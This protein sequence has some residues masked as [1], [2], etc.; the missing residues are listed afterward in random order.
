MRRIGRIL[1]W[2]AAILLGL[3]LLLV[4]LLLIAG[5]TAP[6]QRW[7]ARLTPDLTA[8]TIHLT[9]LSGRFPDRLRA[10]T[11]TIGDQAGPYLTVH[12]VA[13][14]WSPLQLLRATLDIDRLD[15]AAA[16]LARMPLSSD[17]QEQYGRAGKGQVA[18][19]PG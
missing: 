4:A 18:T 17:E 1:A 14:D 19:V 2:T 3:P 7:I 6:G 8:G 13:F 12:G 10:T 5:N 16:D 11:L 15:A 9:G